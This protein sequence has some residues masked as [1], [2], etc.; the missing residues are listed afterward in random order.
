MNNK[1]IWENKRMGEMNETKVIEVPFE[2]KAKARELGIIFNKTDRKWYIPDGISVDRELVIRNLLLLT[3]E[4]ILSEPTNNEQEEFVQPNKELLSLNQSMIETWE[5]LI[6]SEEPLKIALAIKEIGMPADTQLR[7]R[8]LKILGLR[9][10]GDYPITYD[11]M[12]ICSESFASIY[13]EEYVSTLV[14]KVITGAKPYTE[15][16]KEADITEEEKALLLFILPL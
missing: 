14:A 10:P 13:T 6:A 3:E 2:K 11:G 9:R 15:E 16:I 7:T 1:K 8:L 5:N 4:P 12:F